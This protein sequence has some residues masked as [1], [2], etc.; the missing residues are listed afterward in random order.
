MLWIAGAAVAALGLVWLLLSHPWSSATAPVAAPAA[1]QPQAPQTAPSTPAG[2]GSG[3][4]ALENPLRMAELALEAGMLVEPE[5]YS[6]WSLF[7]QVLDA[8]PGNAAAKDGLNRVAEQLLDR[9][10]VALEQGRYDD[11]RN[12]A[13]R[14]LSALPDDADAASLLAK[15][16]A[17]EPKPAPAAARNRTAP[18]APAPKPAP[19]K[20]A[21]PPPEPTVAEQPQPRVDRVLETRDAFRAAMSENRLLTPADGSAKHYVDLLMKIAPDN[22]MTKSAQRVLFDE[23]ITRSREA[24][25]ALDTDAARTWI[26]EAE[27]LGVD[28]AAVTRARSALTDSLVARE[29]QRPLPASAL[30]VTH[31]EPPQ[32]PGGAAR[33][34]LEGWVDV[35]FT[36]ATDGTTQD[37]SVSDASDKAYFRDESV[38]AVAQWRFEPRVYLGRTIPQRLF[39]RIRFTLD[40]SG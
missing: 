7:K 35:E 6:A 29:S 3:D 24:L 18:S 17:N 28:P 31:Y 27:Q 38:E 25:E 11:A 20:K 16:E 13:Q 30:K 5:D 22:D 26:D 32:Y 21:A 14:I 39:T 9:A 36:V 4:N 19:P 2:R 23:L 1:V 15:V 34:G 10:G 8:D 33:R 40:D 37:I 12:T